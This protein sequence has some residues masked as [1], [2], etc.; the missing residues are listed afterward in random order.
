MGDRLYYGVYV[1]SSL[2]ST[3]H[4]AGARY[5]KWQSDTT[6]FC[7]SFSERDNDYGGVYLFLDSIVSVCLL[8]KSIWMDVLCSWNKR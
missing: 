2:C 7:H 8:W 4:L 1:F 6:L 5:A 3:L